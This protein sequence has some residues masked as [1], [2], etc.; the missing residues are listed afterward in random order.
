[1]RVKQLKELV[2][3]TIMFSLK[4][5]SLSFQIQNSPLNW[6][7]CFIYFARCHFRTAHMWNIEKD[8]PELASVYK[9]GLGSENCGCLSEFSNICKL[10]ILWGKWVLHCWH[11]WCWWRLCGCG[12]SNENENISLDSNKQRFG[13]DCGLCWCFSF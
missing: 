12:E 9:Q 7:L 11:C 6:N 13:C 8:T 4:Q 10:N 2:T 1:M 3:S 5:C